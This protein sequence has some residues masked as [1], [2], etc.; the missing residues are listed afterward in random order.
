MVDDMNK[1]TD[2]GITLL[3]LGPGAFGLLT[4]EAYQW[5]SGIDTLYLRTRHHPTVADLPG[6]LRLV[7]FDDVYD[8]HDSFD[9]VY[10]HIVESVMKRGRSTEGITYAVPGH[11]FVA[12]ATCPEI[13][14]RAK[15]EGIKVR[16]IEGLSFLEPTCRV[17][18]IDPFS[19]L[20]LVDA[21]QL[22]LKQ[23]PG[24]PP[25]EPALIAQIY[26]RS[27]ASDVKLTL[28]TA[29]PDS[30]PVKLVHGAGTAQ[31]LVEELP[32]YEVDHSPHLGL[33][34]SLFVPPLSESASFE[35][36]QEVVA[37]LRAPDGCP[38]DREQTHLSLRPF[39]LEEAYEVLDALDREDMA[40][41]QEELGDLLLQIILHAQIAA[42]EGDF[43]IH[44][45]ITGISDKLI[46]R[47]P[48]VFSEVDVDDVA[49]GIHNWE[50]I[51][52]DERKENDLNEKNGLLGGV[53]LALPALLQAEELIE[54]ATRVGF[55]YFKR[56]GNIEHIHNILRALDQTPQA[57]KPALIGQLFLAMTRYAHAEGIQA[58]SIVRE[59]LGHFR[60]HFGAMEARVIAS[61]R[62]LIDLNEEEKSRLWSTFEGDRPGMDP[63]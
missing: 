36:F 3:G 25:S 44:D 24:T 33:L 46:R 40:E 1:K 37:R 22:A 52:A 61:G 56:L 43:T 53:P 4:R 10:D 29:Y 48:H 47:H 5:L 11:P 63:S 58:E 8:S 2:G 60:A 54:R 6:S 27:V 9:A 35:A 51:K 18:G 55:D 32:L 19:G 13:A 38:W 62:S 23:T 28:M 26:S 39:L 49:G 57:Q 12:E 42:E 59:A 7:S 20:V 34:S 30:H 15:A 41:L 21:M 17:L 45:V 31:E 16:V 50:A 14:S